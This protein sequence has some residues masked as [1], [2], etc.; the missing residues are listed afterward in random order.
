[1]LFIV[2]APSGAGK[3]TLCRELLTRF[4]EMKLSISHTTRAMRE[5]EVDGVDY[6]FVDGDLFDSMARQGRFAEWAEVHDNCYGT[7]IERLEELRMAGVDVLLD[8]D[9]QGADQIRSNYGHGI[10]VFILPPSVEELERRLRGRGTDRPEV[11]S[12]R[13]DNARFE[14][15]QASRY[16]YI[17]VNDE[18]P[19]AFEQFRSIVIAEHC[20]ARRVVTP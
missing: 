13:I 1:M 8:I 2:S 7:G 18:L 3:T 19:V 20:R 11:I 15:D 4:P 5:G 17:I 12:R 6:H 14:M 16:D 10:F 9:Y